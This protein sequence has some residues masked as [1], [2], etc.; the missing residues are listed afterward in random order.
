MCIRVHAKGDFVLTFGNG[1]SEL[2]EPF[3][4][5]GQKAHE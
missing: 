2:I 5:P 3:E 4:T 1:G